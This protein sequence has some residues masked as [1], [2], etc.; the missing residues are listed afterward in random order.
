MEPNASSVTAIGIMYIAGLGA[1][2]ITWILCI[3]TPKTINR[4]GM[5]ISE[6]LGKLSFPSIGGFFS[7]IDDFFYRLLG[8]K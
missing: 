4:L 1:A 6:S 8:G 5:I 2:I 7:K 3:I